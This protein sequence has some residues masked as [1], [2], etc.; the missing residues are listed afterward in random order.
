MF[1]SLSEGEVL[2]ETRLG[3]GW[4][5]ACQQLKQGSVVG[6]RISAGGEVVGPTP[7]SLFP[8]VIGEVSAGE[9]CGLWVV[10]MCEK[11]TVTICVC[12]VPGIEARGPHLCK[13]AAL[14]CEKI[15]LIQFVEMISYLRFVWFWGHT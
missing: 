4:M 10:R 8:E 15:I 6:W 5:M 14:L 13:A 3:L 9:S 7:C 1:G 2:H 12:L 11:I